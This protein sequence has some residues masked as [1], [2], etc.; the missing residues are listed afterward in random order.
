MG[1]IMKD[2]DEQVVQDFLT[3]IY[4]KNYARA[5]V[6]VEYAR[7]LVELGMQ[8]YQTGGQNQDIDQQIADT[9]RAARLE[10]RAEQARQRKSGAY[11]HPKEAT[12][13]DIIDFSHTRTFFDYGANNLKIINIL[14]SVYRNM[15][16]VAVDIIPPETAGEFTQ[17]HRGQYFQ[18][19]PDLS[20][21]DRPEIMQTAPDMIN[22]KLVLH[23]FESNQ[24][25]RRLLQHLQKLAKPHTQILLWEETFDVNPQS[26]AEITQHNNQLGI[27][28]DEA[29]TAQWHTLTS[30]QKKLA[31]LINDMMINYANPHMPWTNLYKSWQEWCTLFAE[32]G[33][34]LRQEYNLGIRLNGKLQHGMQIVGVFTK[35]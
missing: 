33:F 6:N 27:Q 23:H 14:A 13:W 20:D 30:E 1:L 3:E 19:Q 21:F 17:P 34:A 8:K 4:T 10:K 11:T 32:A 5:G 15:Q 18:I 35:K 24:Q 28:T 26:A 31:L 16:F 29:L 22:I 9:M 7:Q 12:L 2:K 25:L